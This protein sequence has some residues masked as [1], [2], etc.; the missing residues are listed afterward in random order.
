MQYDQ[1]A[2]E[3]KPI[4]SSGPQRPRISRVARHRQRCRGTRDLLDESSTGG[5]V[6]DIAGPRAR[7][8][9]VLPIF[10]GV[11]QRCCAGRVARRS[12]R[13]RASRAVAKHRWTTPRR[14]VGRARRRVSG[15]LG[16]QR[17]AHDRDRPRVTRRRPALPSV[18][19][20]LLNGV[21]LALKNVAAGV[22]GPG[23]RDGR[24]VAGV[25]SRAEPRRR[26]STGPRGLGHRSG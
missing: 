3:W 12:W 25:L 13:G 16:A 9:R 8:R 17:C 21:T 11:D 14:R 18:R 7:R 20:R 15:F 5:R 26:P 19:T 23:S 1:T 10:P 4:G 2:G 6:V 22:V 24:A